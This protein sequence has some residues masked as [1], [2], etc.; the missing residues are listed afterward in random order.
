MDMSSHKLVLNEE[1]LKTLDDHKRHIFVFEW[2]RSLDQSLSG[3]QKNDIKE[4]QKELMNQLLVRIQEPTGPPTRRLVARCLATLFS[5][6]DTFLLFEAINKCNDI[7]KNKDDSPSYQPIRLAA[8]TCLGTMYEKLGRLMGRSYEDTVQ[9]L[10]KSIKNAESQTRSEIYLT[11]EKI[12]SGMGSAANSV[13]REIYKHIKSGMTDRAM[14]VRSS[15]AKCLHKMLSCAPFLYT[16]ELENVFSLCFRSLDGSNYEVRCAVSLVLGTLVAQTQQPPSQ[17]MSQQTTKTRIVSLEEALNLLASGFLRGGIGSLKS[18]GEM[19]K[20]VT[21]SRETRVGVTHGYVVLV[22]VMG[23]SWLERHLLQ[24]L[25]HLLDLLAN[26]KTSSTHMEAVASRKCVAFVLRSVL[27]RQLSEKAQLQA[28]KE[29]TNI[30]NRYLNA[31]INDSNGDKSTNN[32]SAAANAVKDSLQVDIQLIQHVLVCALLEI[33][34]LIKSLSTSCITVVTDTHLS[35]IDTIAS[36]VVHPSSCARLSAAWCLRCIAVAA[37]S[38]LTPLIE[39]SLERL[40]TLKS[41]PETISGYSCALSALLGA[42]CQTPLGIPHNKG[43][44]IFNI[45]EDLLRSASQNSRLSLQRTQAGWQLIGSIMTLG[46]PVIKGLLPRLLLLW[47]NSFPRSSKELESEKARGDAFTW[48]ITLENR[49]GALA[50]MSSFLAHCD[51]LATDEVKRRLLTPIESAF[52]MLAALSVVFKSYGTAVKASA[53]MVRLR[54]YETLLLLPP[55]S[56]DNCYTNLLRLL[57][58]EFTLTENVA[59]TTSSLLRSFC[60]SDDDTILGSWLQETDHKAIEDQMEPNRK[61]DKEFLQSNSSSSSGAIE[62]DTTHLYRLLSNKSVVPDPYPLGVAVIDKSALVFSAVFPFVANKHRIQMLN[63]FN[64]CIKHAKAARQEAVQIN[65][66]TAILGA[67]KVLAES[68]M[69]LGTDEVKRLIVN[70]ILNTMSHSNPLLRCASAEALGR[71]GQIM[72]DGRFVAEMAQ[73][74]FD[75]L[76]SARDALSRTGHSL[77]LG[78]I[79]RYVGGLGSSQHLNTGISILLAL[80][81]DNSNTTVQVWALHALTLIADSGGPMFRSYVE[82]TLSH[83][84]KLLL[85]V[86]MSY[87]DVHQC[88]GKCLS[89]MITTIGPELQSNTNSICATR[90]TLLVACAIMQEHDDFLVQAEAI[91]CLQQLHMFAP[92]HV[93]LST[94]VPV[95]CEAIRSSHLMLRRASV[96]CLHQLSQREAKEVS[97][98]VYLWTKDSKNDNFKKVFNTSLSGD[99]GL[100]GM[101][102]SMLDYEKDEITINNIHK[103]IQSLVQTLGSEYLSQWLNLCREVLTASD[104]NSAISSPDKDVDIENDEMVDVEE[105]F[106]AGEEL[107]THPPI[108]P[109]WLTRVFTTQTLCRIINSCENASNSEIHFDLLLARERRALS[110]SKEDFLALHLSDLIRMAFMAATS[111]SDDLRLEGLIALQLIIDKF[112]KVPEPEFPDHVILEQYQAQVGA[113]LRPAFSPD[114]PSHVTAMACQVCSAW[115]GSGVARDLNDLR[116]VNQLLVS[117]LTKLQKD[118]SSR[119]Y[120]E[121]ASTIEKLAILKAWAEVYVVSMDQNTT[122][123]QNINNSEDCDNNIESLLHLVEPELPSLSK[124][125]LSA[126]RDHALLTL[127]EEFSSQLPHE[128]GAFYTS[129]TIEIARPRYRASWPPILHAAALWLCS[130]GFKSDCETNFNEERFHLLFGICMEALCNPR[131]SEPLSYV[132]V[133]LKSLQQL[134]CHPYPESLLGKDHQLSIELSNVLHRLLLTRETSE[135]QLLI[136][137]IAQIV[138]QSQLNHLENEKK[139]I[140]R[141]LAPAN[142]EPHN[143]DKVLANLG[144]GTESGDIIP[145]QSLV[146]ALLEVCLCVLVRQMPQLSPVLANTPG[147]AVIVQKNNLRLTDESTELIGRSLQILC[148]LPMLCSPKGSTII[149]PSILYLVTGVLKESATQLNGEFIDNQPITS[150]FNCLRTLSSSSLTKNSICSQKWTE[151][152]QSTLAVILDL[153]HTDE[154]KPDDIITLIAVGIFIVKAPSDV[155]QVPNLQYPAINLLKQSLQSDRKIVQLKCIQTIRTIF[156]H[157]NHNVSVPYI[158]ILAP[159]MIELLNNLVKQIKLITCVSQMESQII[160]ELFASLEVLLEIA[161]NDKKANILNIYLPLM[162]NILSDDN[163]SRLKEY[164]R[165]LHNYALQKLTS[166]GPKYP[167]EFRQVIGSVPQ[168]RNS[169]ENAIR[170]QQ[171]SE[172]NVQNP[173]E[174]ISVYKETKASIKLKVDFSNYTDS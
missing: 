8:I 132:L 61:L 164:R 32:S 64:E 116:R 57:V 72:N 16:T 134:L 67:L 39:R 13:H 147:L 106:K 126:L 92:K 114:T 88:I 128:G 31:N 83:C 80:A 56:Y 102:I 1:L 120:N 18:A 105:R 124:Y 130:N 26:P 29:L 84:L 153:C 161:S 10:L 169:L 150:V 137:N 4:C 79:H 24:F 7:L 33:G 162:L 6:G 167:Q 115:I 37:P 96:A 172:N 123:K 20:G 145:G 66:L 58:S 174:S 45:A 86:P 110:G 69:S 121:S 12:V 75:K 109:R 170:N 104:P 52:T 68:K 171:K 2:L 36:I 113:A 154:P 43:K 89:A 28:I 119:L 19:I 50:A 22:S 165:T 23:S 138:T 21:V 98:H 168:F 148:D 159:R 54:L 82:P 94:L 111:D 77:A 71:C 87:C 78:C 90:S 34:C 62:H 152:L 91:G 151:L 25:T 108:S 160:L 49:A 65:I 118:S 97:E 40:E 101:L 163:I 51:K 135:C 9:L 27:G 11:L 95:L 55:Q 76:K 17:L 166:I 38:Q 30:L 93:N 144:E 46:P 133:C 155:V 141:E 139:K 129:D 15:A 136:L 112:S 100:A 149:L 103:I 59:N 48:Q 140:L 41:N 5:V 53:A 122:Y 146:Y 35:L 74:C 156:E 127:P 73:Q 85:S 60:H 143:S 158:H 63:H 107:S 157:N 47:K 131:S 125:W 173:T 117:S 44:L 81:Q 42:V 99:H 142:Q 3:V 14:I 70:F